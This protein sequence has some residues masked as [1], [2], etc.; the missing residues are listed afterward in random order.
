MLTNLDFDV[1]SITCANMF[2][3][4]TNADRMWVAIGT[5]AECHL[6]AGEVYIEQSPGKV[7]DLEACKKSCEAAPACQSITFHRSRWCSHYSTP[8]SNTKYKKGAT[9]MGL[10]VKPKWVQVGSK[11]VC[12][13]TSGEV[14]NKESS[15]P[16]T[17]LEACQKSCEN[18]P[19]CESITL[20]DDDWCAHYSTSCTKTLSH[21]KAIASFRIVFS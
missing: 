16:V 17:S 18:A 19:K 3:C 8:C 15:G 6:K 7:A 20:F 13:T 12:D 1:L 21:A 11:V 2:L 5:D 10:R 4:T 14:Y 9:A